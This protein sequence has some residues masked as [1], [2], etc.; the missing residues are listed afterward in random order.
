MTDTRDPGLQAERTRLAWRRSA[1]AMTVV[2]LLTVRLALTAGPSGA[3]VA[4]VAVVAVLGWAA[5]VT[6]CWRRASGTSRPHT[7][8]RTLA[9]AALATAGFAGLGVLLV[10]HGL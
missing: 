1:L 9:A 10:V 4:V 3:S 7:G 6:L 2:L 8:G 5:V